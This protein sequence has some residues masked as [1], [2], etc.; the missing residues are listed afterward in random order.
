MIVKSGPRRRMEVLALKRSGV[1]S[2]FP[3]KRDDS[4]KTVGRKR[5]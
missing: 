1:G 4:R 3:L 2:S 5:Q